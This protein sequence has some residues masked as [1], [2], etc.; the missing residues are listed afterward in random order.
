MCGIAGHVGFENVSAKN[1]K[2]ALRS[3]QSRGPDNSGFENILVGN[4]KATL[5]HTRLSIIDLD[6]RSNQP[7]SRDGRTLVFNGEI[8]NFLE[9]RSELQKLGHKFTTNS[10]TEVVLAA[11]CEYGLNCVDHFEGMWAFALVDHV[12]KSI[13]LSRDRFAEKPL[14]YFVAE[15][16]IYFSSET[17]TLESLVGT[18]FPVNKAQVKRYLV[19]GYKSLYKYNECFLDGVRELNYGEHLIV[20]QDLSLETVKYFRPRLIIDESMSPEDAVSLTRDR[21]INSMALR[22][23]S[24]VPI[25]FCLSGGVDSAALVSIAAKE[26]NHKVTAF[27]IIDPD[28]RYNEEANIRKTVED[29]DCNWRKI[30]LTPEGMM[31]RLQSLVEYHNAPIATI[32]YLVHSMLSERMAE[33]GFKI[34]I[35]GTGADELF[36]GY[37]DHFNLFLYDVRD[38]PDFDHYLQDWKNGP[39][40]FIRN[41]FLKDPKLYLSNKN[42]RD[43]IYLDSKKFELFLK[44]EF[45]EV[46]IESDFP[47][48]S[49]LRKR[50]LNEVFYEG[51]RVILN[52][53]DLNSMKSSIE[54]R[55]PYLDNGLFS[56]AYSIPSRHLI[57]NGY[58]KFILRE[59]MRGI[60]NDTVR[61][62]KSKKGFNASI[63]SVVDFAS[64]DVKDFLLEDS[65]LYDV[66]D[67][68]KITTLFNTDAKSNSVSKFLFNFICVKLFMKSRNF[69]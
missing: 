29:T 5:L 25:A 30:D 18:K 9:I 36:T 32:S 12:T 48:D 60:L 24:D 46:F 1:V 43:H 62:D 21:L 56:L 4:L 26:L 55:S 44:D 50:M 53:D 65:P 16:G 49:L 19:N 13:V 17:K 20:K 47:T 52:Q 57:K 66:V 33:E 34:S 58:G 31:D 67:R 35:S 23:R 61:L 28:E 3:M 6:P 11:Y 7:F 27:S 10:D 22:M 41:P 59:S 51:S 64:E 14:Y 63:D 40:Q 54:N 45:A 42:F 68:K 38:S 69:A 8:Y 39:G 2:N 37:Y 15:H